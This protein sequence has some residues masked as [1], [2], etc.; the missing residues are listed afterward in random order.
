MAYTLAR[1][2]GFVS[3]DSLMVKYPLK[4]LKRKKVVNREMALHYFQQFKQL[5]DKMATSKPDPAIRIA[6]KG[7][8][9]Y[10]LNEDY[11]PRVAAK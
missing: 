9:F 6:H 4:K 5:A 8:S 7:E 11:M 2:I 10:W 3:T 1:N